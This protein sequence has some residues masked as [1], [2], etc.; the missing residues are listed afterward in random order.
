M[1]HEEAAMPAGEIR[2]DGRVPDGV[3]VPGIR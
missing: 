2:C 1:T 3:S